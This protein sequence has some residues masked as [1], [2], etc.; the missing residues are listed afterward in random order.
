MNTAPIM[1]IIIPKT[2]IP[3][4]IPKIR[5]IEDPVLELKSVVEPK[6]PEELGPCKVPN[7]LSLFDKDLPCNYKI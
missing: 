1:V 5:P 2:N 6:E 3:D 7:R 4:T